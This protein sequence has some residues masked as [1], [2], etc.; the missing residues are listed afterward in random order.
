MID[1]KKRRSVYLGFPFE[2]KTT[3]K[4]NSFYQ[5]LN[6]YDF[7]QGFAVRFFIDCARKCFFFI[8]S[9]FLFWKQLNS[10][11]FIKL[12]LTKIISLILVKEKN[13]DW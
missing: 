10:M 12:M 5:I 3:F 13:L 11:G 4:L 9:S 1:Y 2:L 7:R 8:F 6:F